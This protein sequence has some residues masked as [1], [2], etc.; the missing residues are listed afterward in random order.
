[1]RITQSDVQLN[2]A[3][4]LVTLESTSAYILVK[5][6]CVVKFRFSDSHRDIASVTSS[7]THQPVTSLPWFAN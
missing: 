6:W 2:S 3:L 4:F 5:E 1:M 7:F